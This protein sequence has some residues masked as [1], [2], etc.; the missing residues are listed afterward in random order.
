MLELKRRLWNFIKAYI[1]K[2]HWRPTYQFQTAQFYQQGKGEYARKL[3]KKRLRCL[4]MCATDKAL[5][6]DGFT[7]GFFIK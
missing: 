5:G 3:R 4:K 2:H 1:Q 7:T 6:P